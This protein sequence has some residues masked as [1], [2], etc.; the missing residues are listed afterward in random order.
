MN[1]S[2][3]IPIPWFPRTVS[4]L[5]SIGKTL[6]KARDDEANQDHPQFTDKEYRK[7]RDFIADVSHNYKMGERIPDIPYTKEETDLWVMINA[8]LG[9]LH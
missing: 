8:K 9:V 3:P 2:K 4:D 1:I 6:I 7:R 5:N